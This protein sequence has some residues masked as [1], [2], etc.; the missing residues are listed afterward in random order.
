MQKS[1]EPAP[2][3]KEAQNVAADRPVE[4]L[5]MHHE[6]TLGLRTIDRDIRDEDVL[7]AP[8]LSESG[9]RWSFF[10]RR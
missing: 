2:T 5:R 3:L 8:V 7:R 6:A 9:R 1:Y 4:S 10:R